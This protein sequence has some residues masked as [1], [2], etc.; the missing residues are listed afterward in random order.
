MVSMPR[1]SVRTAAA[2]GVMVALIAVGA[3]TASALPGAPPRS[4]ARA[5]S[6][7]VTAWTRSVCQAFG[8]WDQ[9]LL[10]LGATVSSPADLAAAKTA[11]TRFLT[12]ATATTAKLVK[13]LK[14]AGVP[15][16]PHGSAIGQ[17][18]VHAAQGLKDGFAQAQSAAR[19]LSTTDPGAF[20][21]AEAALV[22]QIN[23]AASTL[24]A[25]I[26][27]AATTYQAPSLDRAFR[28]TSACTT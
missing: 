24:N 11:I 4:V 14:A 16:I 23:T 8:R 19:R 1:R 15:R 9:Q 26:T 5:P 27:Q 20:A 22:S 7:S 3:G 17:L 6:V 18:F 12:G 2:T 10:K 21:P 13:D 28:T 25:T